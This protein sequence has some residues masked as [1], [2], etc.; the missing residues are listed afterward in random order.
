[1]NKEELR[2]FPLGGRMMKDKK[3]NDNIYGYLQSISYLNKD[4][5]RFIY[6]SD[7]SPTKI[8]RYFKSCEGME[9]SLST[10]KRNLTLFK[11]KKVG[12]LVE[13][14]TMDNYNREVD[15]YFLPMIEDEP[16][17][18]IPL[19]TLK[20]LVDTSN[21]N[22]IK[23]YVYLLNK[24]GW[25]KDYTFTKGELIEG[26][27]YNPNSR[28][29]DGRY[30]SYEMMDNILLCL[31]NNGLLDYVEFYDTNNEGKPTPKHKITFVGTKVKGMRK[32]KTPQPQSEFVF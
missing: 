22:V 12:L 28:N 23:T 29:K 11:S 5:E 13:G 16:Y 14:K 21:G 24:Y 15:V 25:K 20:Y 31:V 10:V 7:V 30:V 8:E 1:M 27:G 32:A 19:E 3:V 9:I 4:G 26:I 18:L 17:K 6:K 2:Y